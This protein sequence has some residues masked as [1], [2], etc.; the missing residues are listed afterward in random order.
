MQMQKLIKI[1]TELK[2]PKSNYNSFGEYYYRSAEDIMEAIKPLLKKHDCLLVISDTIKMIGDRIYVCAEAKISD[3]ENSV[4]VTGYA[5]ETE[6]KKK[7]DASQLTGAASSY[8]RKYALA[9]L[10]LLDDTKD[11]DAT[12]KHEDTRPE[13]NESTEAFARAIVWLVEGGTVD[14]IEKKYKLTDKVKKSLTAAAEA[15]KKQPK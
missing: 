3:G 6:E 14:Q 2:V 5:R 8:A 13:L 7:S 9:G 10:F 11:A 1:Q 12:N 4:T 15:A